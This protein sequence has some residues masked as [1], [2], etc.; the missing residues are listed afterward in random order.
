MKKRTP[1]TLLSLL[2]LITF[3]IPAPSKA[4][5]AQQPIKI[6]M[7]DEYIYTDVEPIIRDDRVLVPIRFI[8]ENFN[9]DVEWKEDTQTVI[10]SKPGRL[11][12]MRIGENNVQDGS[13]AM[14]ETDTVPII[15]KDRTMVPV[16]FVSEWMG[17]KVDWDNNTRT[18]IIDS[19]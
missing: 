9:Y 11:L 17:L 4:Q 8:A 19:W 12:A 1:I 2:L 3:I 14:Y 6:R 13:W 16:R 10:L 7:F 18:V 5:A 15:Y